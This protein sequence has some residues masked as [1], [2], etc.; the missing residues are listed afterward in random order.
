MGSGKKAAGQSFPSVQEIRAGPFPEEIGHE[1]DATVLAFD[2][3]SSCVGW[4]LGIGPD[5]VSWGKFVFKSTAKIGEKL[6]AFEEW[7]SI[8]VDTYQPDRLILEKPLS[9]KGN[10]TQRHSELIGVVRTVWRRKTGKEIL[11]AWLISPMTIKRTMN[12]KRGASHSD[13]KRLMVHK[14]NDMY[15]LKLKYHQ[16]SKLI[17]EDDVA[18]A[19]AV[20]TTYVKKNRGVDPRKAS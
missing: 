15:G 11:P 18:D 5:L 4:A 7:L 12:V 6:V 17:T 14:I 1:N 16:N 19:I 20:W 10:T 13:N 9:R 8:L 3:S 2:I